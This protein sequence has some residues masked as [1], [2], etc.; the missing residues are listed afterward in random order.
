M[1][2]RP[3]REGK[4]SG[5]SRKQKMSKSKQNSTKVSAQRH[6]AQAEGSATQNQLV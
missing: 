2:E 1:M 5:M 6:W 3:K 4:A